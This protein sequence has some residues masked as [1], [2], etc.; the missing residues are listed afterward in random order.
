M[1]AF[2]NK[3]GGGKL[4]I[5]YLFAAVSVIIGIGGYGYH[6]YSL[7][8]DLQINK[9]QP[10]VEKLIRDLRL[11]HT[12][13][14]R[15]P[16]NFPEINQLIWRTRPTTDYGKD[17]RQARTKNYYYFYTKVSDETCAF[18]ALPQ[19]P[20]RHYGSSFFIVLSLG[21]M[22][23]WKGAEMSDESIAQIPAVPSPVMLAELKMQ[24][25]PPRVFAARK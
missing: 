19:G 25:L 22:R 6:L 12:Q 14:R 1:K 18:L 3:L 13:I 5:I 17:G 2:Q 20:Q 4:R 8:R 9:P 7:F 23:A 21:W 16:Q 15:F 11:Y 10:Q 24:E